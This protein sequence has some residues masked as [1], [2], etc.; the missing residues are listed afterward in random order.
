MAYHSSL[1]GFKQKMRKT[2][3]ILSMFLLVF[4]SSASA[5]IDWIQGDVPDWLYGML[6]YDGNINITFDGDFTLNSTAVDTNESVRMENIVGTSCSAGDFIYD[7]SEDGTPICDTPAV[8][9]DTNLSSGGTISGNL[10]I[11][12]PYKLTVQGETILQ[13]I[14]TVQNVTP[15]THN[16]YALGNSTN[17]FNKIYATNIYNENFYGNYIN[18]SEINSTNINSDNVNSTT[19]EVDENI[20]LGG[21]KIKKDGDD[22]AIVLI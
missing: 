22:L 16:L 15:V 14:A 4:I 19:V 1:L 13:G 10:I 6:I 20:T 8:S 18:A 21:F 12:S 9:G 5:T 11:A 2:T 7:F 3:I 17:W